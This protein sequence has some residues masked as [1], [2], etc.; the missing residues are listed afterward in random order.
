MPGVWVALLELP[1]CLF[2]QVWGAF[3]FPAGECCWLGLGTW[4][5]VWGCY[6]IGAS[7]WFSRGGWVHVVLLGDLQFDAL[8]RVCVPGWLLLI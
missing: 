7:G 6:N 2:G 4:V 1:G 5:L 3:G 8:V